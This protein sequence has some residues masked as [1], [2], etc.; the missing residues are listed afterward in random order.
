MN[1]QQL[2]KVQDTVEEILRLMEVEAHVSLELGESQVIQVQ[3]DGAELGALIGHHGE[4]LVALQ[5]ILS[6]I[7][8][9]QDP[10]EG[11]DDARYK[12]LVDVGNYRQRQEESLQALARRSAERVRFTKKPL[13]LPVMSAYDRRIVHMALQQEPDVVGESEGEGRDR[14]LVVRLRDE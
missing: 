12:V 6:L 4:T 1:S 7:I 2:A 8:N 10:A 3:I 14:R 5:T 9:R 11:D 13:P